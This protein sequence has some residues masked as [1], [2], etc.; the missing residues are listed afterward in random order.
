[1]IDADFYIGRNQDVSIVKKSSSGGIFSL[2]ANWIF[3]H[4]GVVFGAVYDAESKR[5]VHTKAD[6]YAEL[7]RMRKSK[8]VWSDYTV[9]LAAVKAALEADQYVLFTGTP[10]QVYAVKQKF[11]GF[12]KLILLDL[13]CHGTL[14]P[15]YLSDYIRSLENDI[16]DV[17][18]RN[19]SVDGQHNYMFSAF[20]Q[21]R[22]SVVMEEYG[23]NILTNLYVNSAGIRK[24]CFRCLFCT[25]KHDSDIT[26]GDV[27][28]DELAKRHGFDKHHLSIICVNSEQGTKIFE[29]IKGQ[30]IYKK[31]GW[32]D[33]KEIEK[34]YLPHC[35]C[36]ETWGYNDKLQE[37]FEHQQEI[38]GFVEAAYQC[39]YKD[40]IAFLQELSKYVKGKKIYLYGCGKKGGIIKK[41]IDWYFP[42]W[43]VC[44]Y[45]VTKKTQ[46]VM[47]GLPVYEIG[48][49]QKGKDIYIIVAV[50]DKSEIYEI[51]K[52]IGFC[53]GLQYK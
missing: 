18:F 37:W 23:E 13:Y 26:I 7:S 4:N 1:M 34:Y 3:R 29:D 2:V 32:E 50:F 35:K 25:G 38:V 52:R 17:D 5:I 33:G 28:S 27:D 15:D 9:C 44:G 12:G 10:C 11:F 14:Q 45:I 31:L 21:N 49:L 43:N 20:N 19:E 47:N 36:N 42:V 46:E 51:L 48:E 8:Y 39:K 53:E 16:I 22:E 40:D 24:A 6:S 30:L 41:L